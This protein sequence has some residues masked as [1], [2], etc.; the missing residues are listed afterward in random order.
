MGGRVRTCL[1]LVV[2][3]F[4]LHC[5]MYPCLLP[6]CR[7]PAR[8]LGKV[9]VVCDEADAHVRLPQYAPHRWPGC[10]PLVEIQ[11]CRARHSFRLDMSDV[12][13]PPFSYPSLH[14]GTHPGDGYTDDRKYI[15][16]RPRGLLAN[17]LRYVG[18][19]QPRPQ[20]CGLQARSMF[21]L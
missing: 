18:R 4:G 1:R 17:L 9:N 20:V 8:L 3:I 13:H 7:V 19:E 16:Y 15:L 14:A 2:L 5:L 11:V 10:T 6:V 21:L 12:M